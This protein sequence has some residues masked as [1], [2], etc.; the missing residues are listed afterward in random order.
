[1]WYFL[2]NILFLFP[3]ETAHHFSLDAF[4]LLCRIPLIPTIIRFLYR[5]P[6]SNPIQLFGLDFANPI[7]LSAGLDK[8]GDY[9]EA[10]SLLGFS[11]IEIGTITPLPQEGNPTPRLFR[12]PAQH[13]LI[14]RMGFNNKGAAYVAQKL[15]RTTIPKGLVLGINIGK[16]K[17]TPNESAWKDYISCFETLYPFAHYF[18]I[19]ISSP[20]TPGLRALQ[21]RAPLEEL[22]RTIRSANESKPKPKPIFLKIAPDL[23][24]DQLREIKDLAIDYE[25]D[26]IILGNTSVDRSLLDD[27]E[28][29]VEKMGPGGLSGG[30]IEPLAREK[31]KEIMS[32]PGSIP[33][34]SVGGISSGKEAH[35]RIELG[36]SLVQLYSGLIFQGPGLIAYFLQ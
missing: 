25:I 17:I 6:I 15:A 16:N 22:L 31:L 5:A 26:A 13:A 19:N 8:N 33:I 20:N 27:T 18:T 24:W 23:T 14:N 21:D 2:K 1:M 12:F 4:R 3:A 10:L 34:I 29:A 30:P 11:H 35:L 36:A 7:G 9:I 28:G 32:M